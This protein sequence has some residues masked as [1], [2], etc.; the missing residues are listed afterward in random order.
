MDDD[1]DDVQLEEKVMEVWMVVV[2]VGF[3]WIP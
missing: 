3:V 1:D 2:V